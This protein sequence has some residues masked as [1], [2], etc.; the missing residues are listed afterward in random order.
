MGGERE[1]AAESFGGNQEI[2]SKG[3]RRTKSGR[4]LAYVK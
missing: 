4:G 1:K 3:G 2:L